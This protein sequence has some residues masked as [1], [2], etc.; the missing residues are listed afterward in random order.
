MPTTPFRHRAY[1]GWITDLAAAPDPQADWPSLRL[2]AALLRDYREA[3]VT[4]G[5]LGFNALSLWGLYVARAWPV[6]IVSAVAPERGARVETLIHIAHT[7]GLKVYAGLGVYSWGFERIIAAHP[8]VSRGNP[9]ALCASEPRAWPWMQRVIDYVF[10]RFPVDGVS[11]QSADQGRCPC[12][13]CRVYSDG[14]YHALLNVRAAAYIRSRWP[15]KTVGVN[16]WGMH[17]DDPANLPSL[18]QIG[19]HCDYLIDVTDSSRRRDPAYRATLT[20]ALACDFGTLG[21]PQVEPPQHWDRMRWFLP[22]ARRDAEHLR[23]LAADG[24]RACEYFFHTAANPGDEVSLWVAGKTLAAPHTP[25]SAHLHDA[26][27]H[28]YGLLKTTTRDA[29][30]TLFTDAEDAYFRYLPPTECGTVSLEP[31]ESDHAGEPI[32]LTQRLTPAQRADYARSLERLRAEA[33]RLAPDVPHRDK[34]DKIILCLDGARQ[35]L[36]RLG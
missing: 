35:E 32:Y 34:M 18:I 29:L 4:L 9:R 20:K 11:M 1:L 36:A 7:H 21:G 19:A 27:A 6:D 16:S 31:L 15:G 30:A 2:D 26:L 22:T 25:P 5:G 28:L 23:A 10:T 14:E 24:G 17:F 12:G 8:E 3:A 33:E 13:Q